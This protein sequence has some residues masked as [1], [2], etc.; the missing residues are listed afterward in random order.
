LG[1]SGAEAQKNLKKK[2]WRTAQPGK[3]RR[4]SFLSFFSGPSGPS[5]PQP[6]ANT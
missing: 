6:H 2:T 4:P 5:G 1:A 3:K